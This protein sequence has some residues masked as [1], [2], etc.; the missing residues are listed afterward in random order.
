METPARP[1][2]LLEDETG[3]A[4]R[5]F[6]DVYNE[7]AGFPEFVIRRGLAIALED[8]GLRVRQEVP[9]PVWFRGRRIVTFKADMIVD[10]GLVIEVKATPEIQPYHK[11][12]LF[13][14][15]KATDLEVGLLFNFGRRP[16]FSRVIYE[17]SRKQP[18]TDA[19]TNLDALRQQNDG[20]SP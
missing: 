8:A 6:Y 16:E 4:I 14:Y 12:Q 2:L 13:H 5:A 17:N 20:S 18:R 1:V 10:P 11:A 19:P 15:L 9:L 3:M 7:L